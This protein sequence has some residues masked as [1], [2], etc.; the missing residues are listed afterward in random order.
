MKD[1]R[2][3]I[4][5]GRDNWF[6]KTYG[7]GKF[8]RF[9]ETHPDPSK[10]IVIGFENVISTPR[11]ERFQ[12]WG[13]INDPDCRADRNGGPDICKDSDATGVI[14]IRKT[15][16]ADGKPLYGVSCASCHAGFNPLR[17]PR[18]P[19]EP[20]WFNIHP[21]IGNQYLD[22]GKIFAANLAANDVRRLMFAAW[23]KGTVDTTLLFNDG[24]MNPGTITAFWNLPHRPVFDVGMGA[25]K[26][27]GGQGGEDDVGADL[28]ALRVY[29]NIGVCFNEC[30]ASR[31][32]QPIDLAQCRQACS[33]FPP[34]NEIQ[35]MVTF[36]RSVK[37]P[38]IRGFGKNSRLYRRGG[39]VFAQNCAS[40]HGGSPKI[41]STDE[42][43]ALTSDPAN[44]TNACRALSSNWEAG[45]IW[46]A[47]SSDVYK[48]RVEAGGRGYRNM[49]L[50]GI[51]STAPFL[52]NQSIGDWAEATASPREQ[53]QNFERAMRELL[54]ANRAEKIHVTPVAVGSFPAG[55]PLQYIF[56]RDASSG[57][58]LCDDIVEN[59]GHT[60]GSTLP[61][62]DKDAL[63]HWLR[64]Q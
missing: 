34:E 18:D 35:D 53:I 30:V 22:S 31:P 56:S 55:T 26:S 41:M 44:T 14:G 2:A 17:P 50:A 37:A 60:Y 29:T 33:D 13:V 25:L 20:K 24:I 5:R 47:F 32:G 28:A 42:V 39:R 8:F 7:G 19:N 62:S 15:A 23:P 1:D 51:W 4:K 58:L 59:R 61:E 21:T 45:H 46:A 10:R 54:T 38:K 48:S 6:K 12:K 11:N 52:H 40:C 3:A 57:R 9:L 64:Y 16:G 49:P 27:R 36:M 43:I 63:I